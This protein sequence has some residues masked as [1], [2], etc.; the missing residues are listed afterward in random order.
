MSA[1]ID[2]SSVWQELPVITIRDSGA[3]GENGKWD[4][5]SEHDLMVLKVG[6]LTIGTPDGTLSDAIK[7]SWK[8]M[9]IKNQ[10]HNLGYNKSSWQKYKPS[11]A[12]LDIPTEFILKL[13]DGISAGLVYE[14]LNGI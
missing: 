14:E 11:C 3:D 6:V 12:S 7:S 10:F 9:G 13:L 4:G 8:P 2:F 5:S 1:W